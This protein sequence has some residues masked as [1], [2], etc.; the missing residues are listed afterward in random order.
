MRTLYA[1]LTTTKDNRTVLEVAVRRY[2]TKESRSGLAGERK[3]VA[4][5]F[6]RLFLVATPIR[7]PFP[8]FWSHNL[9]CG[10]RR[11]PP[12]WIPRDLSQGDLPLTLGKVSSVPRPGDSSRWETPLATL[13]C[14]D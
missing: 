2:V 13:R 14:V 6:P 1:V 3:A 10:V 9:S 12:N 11:N 4:Q 8:P 5:N 7:L